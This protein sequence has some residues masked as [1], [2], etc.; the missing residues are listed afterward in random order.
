M[1]LASLL[2]LA[3][4]QEAAVLEVKKAGANEAAEADGSGMTAADLNTLRAWID[5]TIAAWRVP[6]VAIA[7]VTDEKVLLADGIGSRSVN[8]N[9]EVDDSFRLDELGKGWQVAMTTLAHE[10]GAGELVTPSAGGMRNKTTFSNSAS[11]LLELARNTPRNGAS[12]AGCSRWLNR[13]LAVLLLITPT[14]K[15][16]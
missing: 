15:S 11:S 7:I 9:L 6:G 1:L 2:V 16:C 8:D 5:E 4:P 14:F 13:T 10:R 12:A 3:A